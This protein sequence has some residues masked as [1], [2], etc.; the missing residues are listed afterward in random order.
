MT[1]RPRALP[2][3]PPRSAPPRA[4]LQCRGSAGAHLGGG[5]LGRGRRRG[6]GWES[7]SRRRHST[8]GLRRLPP[9]SPSPAAPPTPPTSQSAPPGPPRSSITPPARP[10]GPSP[11]AVC[12]SVRI[13]LALRCLSAPLSLSFAPPPGWGQCSRLALTS[14]GSLPQFPPRSLSVGSLGACVSRS[15]L[16]P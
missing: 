16:T 12:P 6:R 1:R 2:G 8:L 3:E 13:C 5:R 11:A 10:L 9:R 14:L 15:P 7:G 4:G